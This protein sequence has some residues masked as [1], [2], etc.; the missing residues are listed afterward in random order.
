MKQFWVFSKKEIVESVRTKKLLVI[1]FVFAIIGI[2]SPFTAKIMPDLIEN[3]SQVDIEINLAEPNSYDSLEQFF[4]N[5]QQMGLLVFIIT[6]NGIMKNEFASGSLINML[7][8]GLKRRAVI[9]SKISI[10]SL[11][12]TIEIL[13]SFTITWVYTINIFPDQDHNYVLFSVFCIWLFGL[14]LLTLLIFA[15]LLTRSSYGHLLLMALVVI[16]G[17]IVNVFDKVQKYNPITLA[18][19][20][21][22]II[23]GMLEPSYFY[24]SILITILTSVLLLVLS[25]LIFNKK[26]IN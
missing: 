26:S 4:K 11:V 13:V 16:F 3:L 9:L 12:W 6:F 19:K 22:D 2:L 5:T 7:T 17:L 23:K 25:I 18:S 20:N 8:K 1:L 21:M 14:F 15:S 24:P 10:I